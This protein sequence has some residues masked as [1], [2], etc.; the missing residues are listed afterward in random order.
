MNSRNS[1]KSPTGRKKWRFRNKLATILLLLFT[2]A[3]DQDDTIVDPDIGS[4]EQTLIISDEVIDFNTLDLSPFSSSRINTDNR[5]LL[6]FQQRLSGADNQ[7]QVLIHG[8]QLVKDTLYLD[9]GQSVNMGSLNL[10]RIRVI[11]TLINSVPVNFTSFIQSYSGNASG[12]PSG[13]SDIFI[14]AKSTVF[15]NNSSSKRLDP[16]E[17]T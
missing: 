7:I 13:F 15:T 1:C 3:C 6:S 16:F 10:E 4:F 5:V 17:I 11:D 9:Y 12:L 14:S 2:V 8:I